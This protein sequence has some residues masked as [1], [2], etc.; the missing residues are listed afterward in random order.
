MQHTDTKPQQQRLLCLDDSM[1][2]TTTTGTSPTTAPPATTASTASKPPKTTAST[3]TP[4]AA[5]AKPT[6]AAPSAAAVE[7]KHPLML[8]NDVGLTFGRANTFN[9]NTKGGMNLASWS[10][11]P[12]WKHP[13]GCVGNL[14]KSMTGTLNDP[15]ISEE[16]RQFLADLLMQLS[17][18]AAPR[19]VRGVARAPAA[20]G[21]GRRELG[22]PDARR[23]GG[24]VQGQARTN[25]HSPLFRDMRVASPEYTRLRQLAL[26]ISCFRGKSQAATIKVH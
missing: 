26:A 12:V 24:R 23:V 18:S 15:V 14:P 13:K 21:S 7:C 9:D 1:P 19:L 22:L 20:A 25:R 16:G 8:L 6:K 2:G 10:K 11:T 5:T 4:T 17:D 3:G